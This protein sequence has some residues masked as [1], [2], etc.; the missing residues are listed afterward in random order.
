MDV[1]E[2]KVYLDLSDVCLP[3]EPTLTKDDIHKMVEEIKVLLD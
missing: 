3:S 2:V 1:I